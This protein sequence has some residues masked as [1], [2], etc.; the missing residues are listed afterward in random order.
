MGGFLHLKSTAGCQISTLVL[1]GGGCSLVCLDVIQYVE[2]AFTV[3]LLLLFTRN[4]FKVHFISIQ[5]IGFETH[6]RVGY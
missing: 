1:W 4:L 6:N 5:Y 3:I 2:Y